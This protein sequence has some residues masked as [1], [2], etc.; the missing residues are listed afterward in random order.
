M[1]TR[2]E[3]LEQ[4]KEL[5]RKGC[6]C[7]ILLNGH[8]R[9]S[10]HIHYDEDSKKFEIFNYID[11]REQTLTEKQLMEKDYTNIGYAMTRGALFKD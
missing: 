7:F 11:D 1:P 5:A 8:L 2:I 10:K 6:D 4:L 3:S 9:S